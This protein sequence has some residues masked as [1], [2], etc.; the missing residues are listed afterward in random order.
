[1]DVHCDFQGFP[2]KWELP[3]PSGKLTVSVKGI[4]SAPASR[5]DAEAVLNSVYVKGK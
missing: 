2:L 5:V 3:S 1:M 4:A